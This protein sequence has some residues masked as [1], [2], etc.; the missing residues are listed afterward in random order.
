MAQSAGLGLGL[1]VSVGAERTFIAAW[2]LFQRMA[3]G[4]GSGSRGCPAGQ[5]ENHVMW[6]RE[7]RIPNGIVIAD[8]CYRVVIA[9]MP[10]WR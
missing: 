4:L 10:S 8:V 3:V 6:L 2:S 7:R 9:T 1:C 5:S